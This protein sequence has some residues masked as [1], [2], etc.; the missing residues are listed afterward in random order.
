MISFSWMHLVVLVA[1]MVVVIVIAVLVARR[2]RRQGVDTGIAVTLTGSAFF[3]TVSLIAAILTFVG[4]LTQPQ[5]QMTV[6]VQ[7][8]WPTLSAGDA[9]IVGAT[10]ATRGG[11][12]FTHAD[13]A[14]DHVGA[15]ARVL[16]ATG[17]AVGV[18]VPAAIAALIAVACFQ[19]LR[20]HAFAPVVA[21]VALATAFV[22][23]IG[24]ILAPALSEF[25]GSLVS[26][27]LL[28]NVGGAVPEGWDPEGFFPHPAMQVTIP[29]WPVGA[30][31]GFAALAAV[32]KY[33]TQLQR[34]T[35]GL[36]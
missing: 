25:A 28:Q 7:S 14:V 23:L 31:F 20:G 33:G 34:D 4:L 11:G 32:L 15:G 36:V 10:G 13:L 35:E 22:V 27:D 16:W 1:T 30:A 5:V 21:R 6:P 2:W 3:A 18:L 24:G 29:L 9:A 12:G 8:F 26:Q 17:Q 19:L